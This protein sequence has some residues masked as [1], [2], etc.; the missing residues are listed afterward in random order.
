M[1]G[2][3]PKNIPASV[4]QR[5]HNW[6][7]ERHDDMNLV[8]T[9]YALERLL[10]R[11][12]VS[13]YADQFVLKGAM[14]F[15]LWK[16]ESHRPTRDLDL[17]GYG[18]DT[19]ARLTQVFR[20]ICRTEVPDDGLVFDADQL[21]VTEIREDQEYQG[22]R[23]EMRAYLGK[24]RIA[25][26]IDIGFGDVVNPKAEAIDY[27]VL[28]DLPA[29]HIRVYPPETVV[30]EKLQAMVSLGI[31]NSRM[32]DF[33]DLL[34]M[35]RELDFDG[36]RLAES[37]AATFER[38]RTPIP[39]NE[40]L[41]LTGEFGRDAMKVTQWGA[42]LQRLRLEPPVRDFGEVVAAIASFLSPL[43]EAIRQRKAFTMRW[44]RG[45]P[46]RKARQ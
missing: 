35:S 10:Y 36:A 42:F 39:E 31:R 17:L 25:V 9:R 6:A 28:L 20:E 45:G 40:P 34:L 23:V 11:L 18:E 22:R 41:A 29:P 27:P 7:V 26:R 38:R 1:K 19:E 24:T 14:L 30:A 3:Q 33:Y 32:K 46:W 16:P 13:P 2:R 15:A 12:S 5:L 8:L 43:L 4:H 21:R 37:I 44:G